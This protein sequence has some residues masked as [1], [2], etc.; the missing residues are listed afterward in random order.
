[1][2]GATAE[3]ITNA[4]GRFKS[5]NKITNTRL[6]FWPQTGPS[7]QALIAVSRAQPKNNKKNHKTN[8]NDYPNHKTP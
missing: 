8:F 7:D 5:M 6:R 3:S 2:P 1:M 4:K